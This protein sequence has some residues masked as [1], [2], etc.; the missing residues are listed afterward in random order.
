MD[1][2]EILFE[3]GILHV[4]IEMFCT[5]RLEYLCR[6][7]VACWDHKLRIF[8]N[9]GVPALGPNR[10]GCFRDWIC[11]IEIAYELWCV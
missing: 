11:V 4:E 3:F 8:I 10:L 7:G 5:L 9:Y 6:L 1:L 2:V